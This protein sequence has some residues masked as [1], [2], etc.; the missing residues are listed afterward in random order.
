MMRHKLLLLL[1]LLLFKCNALLQGIARVQRPRKKRKHHINSEQI[2]VVV[3]VVII[4]LDLGAESL[5]LG[6]R[7][8]AKDGVAVDASGE[9]LNTSRNVHVVLGHLIVI[10]FV[11]AE[12]RHHLGHRDGAALRDRAA[13]ASERMTRRNV[14]PVL[15]VVPG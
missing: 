12:L 4:G 10:L 1:L 5:D 2:F 6:P 7:K 15:V 13:L 14:D 3:V 11:R 8:V 9:R